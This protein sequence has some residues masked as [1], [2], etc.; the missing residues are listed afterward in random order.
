M[1]FRRYVPS[2][3]GPK[4]HIKEHAYELFN[5]EINLVRRASLGLPNEC[6]IVSYNIAQ[7]MDAAN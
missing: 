4:L 7:V 2:K 6:P 1:E 5:F 3:E